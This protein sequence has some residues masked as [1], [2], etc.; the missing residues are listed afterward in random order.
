[1]PL[2][3]QGELYD[4][5]PVSSPMELQQALLRRPIPLVRTFTENLMTYAL[6]RRV[7]YYDQPTIRAIT[8]K[9]AS[10]GYKMSAFI[11][12]VVTSD[13]FQMQQAAA[14]I[15]PSSGSDR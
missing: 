2:D 3:T 10:G 14:S 5:T 11:L 13:A 1:M 8:Q 12:G 15:E 4:G 6:G 7:E 9:A